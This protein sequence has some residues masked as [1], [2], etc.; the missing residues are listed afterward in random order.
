MAFQV[1]HF[2]VYSR[3]PAAFTD[4]Q[5]L[6]G[7]P[8][9]IGEDI[10]PLLESLELDAGEWISSCICPVPSFLLLFRER[11]KKEFE[12]QDTDNLP[13]AKP[14]LIGGGHGGVSR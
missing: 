6:K 11:L 13:P 12:N 10:R 4:R 2:K 8:G 5:F 7:K 14:R 9:Q 3:P 1:S